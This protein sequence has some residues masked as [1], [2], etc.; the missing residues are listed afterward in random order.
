[1]KKY[2]SEF[3]SFPLYLSSEEIDEPKKTLAEIVNEFNLGEIRE[4][5][6]RIKVAVI[7]DDSEVFDSSTIK[8]SDHYFLDQVERL[9]EIC[10][11]ILQQSK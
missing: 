8:A 7:L 9:F 2:E 1:M 5:L 10:I 6:D 3:L 4:R 11:I